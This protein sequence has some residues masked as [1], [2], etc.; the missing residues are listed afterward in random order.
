MGINSKG[1]KAAGYYFRVS[2]SKAMEE[3][4]MPFKT[5]VMDLFADKNRY[6]IKK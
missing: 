5:F 6:G 2:L 1:N 3:R 4:V